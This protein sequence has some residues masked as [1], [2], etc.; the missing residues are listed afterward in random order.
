M[1]DIQES[2]SSEK[3]NSQDSGIVFSPIEDLLKATN[4]IPPYR[5]GGRQPKG[6]R[7]VGYSMIGF[8]VLMI[9]FVLV[10]ILASQ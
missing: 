6:I 10:A 1:K 2:H 9:A 3:E 7:V 8:F 4:D 5:K